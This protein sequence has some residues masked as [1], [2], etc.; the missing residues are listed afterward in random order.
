MRP[1]EAPGTPGVP[2]FW[3]YELTGLQPVVRRYLAGEELTIED[4]N[5]LRAYLRQWIYAA[6]WS[7][8]R[9]LRDL[10]RRADL[11]TSRK[12]IDRWTYDAVAVGM[13]P[14]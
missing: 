1:R 13:D 11:L 2:L 8:S 12:A 4:C 3:I 10:R 9:E 5:W 6:G 14:W 7:D